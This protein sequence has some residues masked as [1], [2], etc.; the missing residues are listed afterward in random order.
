MLHQRVSETNEGI[1]NEFD[2]KDYDV[3][4][5]K[6]RDRSWMETNQ[7]IKSGIDM[8]NALE[9]GPGPGYLGL[10]WLKKTN[11]THLTGLEI[12]KAM[13]AIAEANAKEYALSH[14]RIRYVLG[15]AME[16]PFEDNTFDAVFSNGSLH[17]WE[18]PQRILN[19]IYRVLKVGGRYFVSDL[20]RNISALLKS[21]ML[22]VT[23]PKSMRKGFTTSVQASYTK[24]ELHRILL[25]TSCKDAAIEENIM[26]L[27][28][29]GQK[30][31]VSE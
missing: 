3:F 20:K 12:S 8:G 26:G 27:V 6:M 16:M 18:N 14:D 24:E 9:V 31:N 2:V 15:N 21:F 7:I 22:S 17:E 29:L 5:R 13:I 19:E 1:Q 10:E 23:K 25:V 11:N 30:T 4:L 28:V